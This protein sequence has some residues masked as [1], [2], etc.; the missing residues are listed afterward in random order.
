M[1]NEFLCCK[2][3]RLKHHLNPGMEKDKVPV[4]TVA[5]SLSLVVALFSVR[6]R[7]TKVKLHW[8]FCAGAS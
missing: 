1:E 6:G 7:K 3:S 4:K 5:Q 2:A 8:H